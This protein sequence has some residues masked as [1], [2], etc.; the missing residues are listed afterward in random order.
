M[1]RVLTGVWMMV[2]AGPSMALELCDEL[3]F[4]RNLVFDQAGYCFGSPLGKV[5]F[6]NAD[7]TTNNPEISS[8]DRAYVAW[9]KE[10]EAE[11]QCEIDTTQTRLSV[12]LPDVR[13][14]LVN[15]VA[16]SPYESACVGWSGQQIALLAGH[17]TQHEVIGYAQA[18]DDIHWE[19]DWQDAPQGW[20]FLTVKRR[21]GVTYAMG[22][23]NVFIDAAYCEMMAG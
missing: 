20:E 8:Q 21:D 3:W 12:A 6:D 23:S 5:V 13:Q 14:R 15:R 9:L 17:G 2:L 7:C 1:I 4:G 22:W 16:P 19:N 11:W 18:G 10:I